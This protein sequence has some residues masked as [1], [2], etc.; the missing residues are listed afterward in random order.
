MENKERGN[1][2]NQYYGAQYGVE[3]TT[4]SPGKTSKAKFVE[5]KT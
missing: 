3:T 1:W 2:G 5:S 4:K